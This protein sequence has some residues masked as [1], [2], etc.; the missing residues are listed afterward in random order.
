MKTCYDEAEYRKQI[1]H[2]RSGAVEDWE[3][4]RN[5]V[6]QGRLRHGLFSAH[7]TLEKVFK[8]PVSG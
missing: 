3:V 1:K 7:L 5:L 6:V 2:W 4:A 8:V